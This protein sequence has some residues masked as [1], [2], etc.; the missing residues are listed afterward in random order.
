MPRE[1]DLELT[2]DYRLETV[3]RPLPDELAAA[4][5]GFAVAAG[6]LPEHQ[7]RTRVGEVVCVLLDGAGEIAG[8]GAVT[9][10]DVPMLA[11]RRLWV[12]RSTLAPDAPEPAWR[13]MLAFARDALE[14][15]FVEAGGIGPIGVCVPIADPVLTTHHPEAW[16]P[17][18]RM[19]YAGYT[20]DD[21]QLRVSYFEGAR[22]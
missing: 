4:L 9:A 10:G 19:L 17:D 7:V 16:W 6:N 13:A 11:G 20:V 15:D 12:Y 21:F 3:P 22:I 2:G 5:I 14:R 18:S 1:D 8:S